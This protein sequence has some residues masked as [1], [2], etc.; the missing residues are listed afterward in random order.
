MTL[1]AGTPATTTRKWQDAG[2]GRKGRRL[3]VVSSQQ[4]P[5]AISGSVTKTG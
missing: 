3:A 4:C 5:V 1:T 2:A